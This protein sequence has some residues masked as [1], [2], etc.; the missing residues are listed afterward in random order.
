M[1]EFAGDDLIRK[2]EATEEAL[3]AYET[4]TRIASNT[5]SKTHPILL[6]SAL[7]LSVFYAAIL[8]HTKKACS[9]AKQTIENA[10]R[11]MLLTEND[12]KDTLLLLQL[13]QENFEIW[14]IE[15]AHREMNDEFL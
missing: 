13:L 11:D 10:Q 7:N 1:A 15:L 8:N 4:A 14:V 12:S 2:G 6:E 5:L 9:L 3:V